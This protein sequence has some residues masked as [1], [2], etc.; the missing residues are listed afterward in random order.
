MIS[1]TFSRIHRTWSEM[2]YAQRRL[3]EIRTGVPMGP[4]VRSR[5]G[6]VSELE[7]LWSL[8]PHLH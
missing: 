8:R 2:D 3:L 6:E 5:R 7:R 4:T 1:K